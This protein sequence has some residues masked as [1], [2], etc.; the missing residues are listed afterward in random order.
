MTGKLIFLKETLRSL[1]TTVRSADQGAPD[2]TQVKSGDHVQT[3]PTS[4]TT[5]WTVG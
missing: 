4:L 5:H 1:A 3:A 2:L